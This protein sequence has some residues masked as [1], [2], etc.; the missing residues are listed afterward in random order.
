M[1]SMHVCTHPYF[2]KLEIINVHA[3]LSAMTC[4]VASPNAGISDMA[5]RGVAASLLEMRDM[6][7]RKQRGGRGEPIMLT[8][9][10][11]AALRKIE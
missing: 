2:A 5:Q 4:V 6:G 1:W 3:H 7:Q 8:R 9:I 10:G 11:R